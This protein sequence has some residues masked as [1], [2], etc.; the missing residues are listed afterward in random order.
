M[1]ERIQ[2]WKEWTK[3]TIPKDKKNLIRRWLRKYHYYQYDEYQP[4]SHLYWSIR[5][6]YKKQ[7]DTTRIRILIVQSVSD[8]YYEGLP[9]RAYNHFV[10]I[11]EDKIVNVTRT[12]IQHP[13]ITLIR[14]DSDYNA[15]K[16]YLQ[17]YIKSIPDTPPQIV[18]QQTINKQELLDTIISIHNKY[19]Y[20]NQFNIH[21]THPDF[22][23]ARI[24]ILPM[25]IIFK[26]LF[27]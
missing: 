11:N 18:N 5:I 20:R 23:F 15:I 17:D 25:E 16:K 27:N 13:R 7:Y 19:G 3:V 24:S 12:D 22:I 26:I 4:Y 14:N 8:W 1:E 6:S 10:D 9:P 21:D 2:K